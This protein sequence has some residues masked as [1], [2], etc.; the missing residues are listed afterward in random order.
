MIQARKESTDKGK[1]SID[2]WLTYS[3][4]MVWGEEITTYMFEAMLSE[5]CACFARCRLDYEIGTHG[6]FPE[7]HEPEYIIHEEAIEF[8]VRKLSKRI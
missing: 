7:S 3:N 5:N 1:F 8:G 2:C 6:M 4:G